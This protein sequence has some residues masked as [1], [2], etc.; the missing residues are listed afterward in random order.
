MSS[1][2]LQVSIVIPVLNEQGNI[3]PLI[4]EIVSALNE[5]LSFEVIVVDDASIDGTR[6]EIDAVKVRHASVHSL[7][8]DV[9]RGQSAAIRSGVKQARAAVVVVLDGDGQNDPADIPTLYAHLDILSDVQMIIGRRIGRR[10]TWIRRCSS[11]IAN[12]VRNVFL[13]DGVTDTGCGLKAFYR[14]DYLELPAF[15]HMHRFLPALIQLRGGSVYCVPV[16]H[17][18]RLHGQSKYGIADRL[19]V[20]IVDLFGVMWLQRRRI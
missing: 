19:W 16:T 4:E 15:D 18:P 17:R 10:D 8:H 5:R 11:R 2:D 3:A 7:H 12:T 9:T 14:D 20:G 1:S 6:Q 13:K